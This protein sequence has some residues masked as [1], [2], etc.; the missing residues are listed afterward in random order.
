[1]RQRFYK[2]AVKLVLVADI[3]LLELEPVGFRNRGEVFK[4]S[5]VG[6][7]VDHADRVLRVADDMPGYGRSDKSG[8][9]GYDDTIHMCIEKWPE[10]K[11]KSQTAI[12]SAF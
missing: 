10:E 9:A 4:I 7:L 5:G 12:A 3:H 11:S 2:H 1:M 8:S 6:E